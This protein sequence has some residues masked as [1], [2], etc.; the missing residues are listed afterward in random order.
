MGTDEK[1]VRS[2]CSL[3]LHH[4]RHHVGTLF[5]QDILLVLIHILF[6][7]GLE[8]YSEKFCLSSQYD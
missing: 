5:G 6:I 4:T 2:L 1:W 7:V 3:Q 8:R